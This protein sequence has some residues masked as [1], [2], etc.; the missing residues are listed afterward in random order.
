[1]ALAWVLRQNI[2]RDMCGPD[3]TILWRAIIMTSTYLQEVIKQS[4][5]FACTKCKHQNRWRSYVNQLMSA[6]CFEDAKLCKGTKYL[7]SCLDI[8]KLI[9]RLQPF[10]AKQS[11][12]VYGCTV[13]SVAGSNLRMY[14]EERNDRGAA[15]GDGKPKPTA[16]PKAAWSSTAESRAEN[17]Q[18]IEWKS[19]RTVPD[20]TRERGKDWGYHNR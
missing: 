4:R 20:F 9:F 6:E 18:G 15:P 3:F 16:L 8:I 2:T 11:L 5:N 10:Q 7:Q 19:K 12:S 13:P 17:H 1:M 14:L